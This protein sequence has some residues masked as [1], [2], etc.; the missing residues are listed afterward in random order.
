MLNII[1]ASYAWCLRCN[2]CSSWFL[3]TRIYQLVY[4]SD[5]SLLLFKLE[6]FVLNTNLFPFYIILCSWY[7]YAC[8]VTIP[9]NHYISVVEHSVTDAN[10][11]SGANH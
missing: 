4:Y 5:Q 7:D 11:C 1:K 3:D 2:I 9:Y 10:Y 8:M 6:I